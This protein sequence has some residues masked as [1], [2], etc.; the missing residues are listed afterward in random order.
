MRWRFKRKALDA[1]AR[2]IGVRA[3]VTWEFARKP[4]GGVT[5][6]FHAGHYVQGKMDSHII[7]VNIRQSILDVLQTIRHE[8]EHALQSEEG[9][10]AI[11]Q[12]SYWSAA[13]VAPTYYDNPYEVAANDAMNNEWE[14]LLRCI[15][16]P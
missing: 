9:H 11:W 5:D 8:L 2:S 15:R 4:A 13:E 10:P 1:Y 16:R 3:P 12:V 6:G 14:D 7:Y